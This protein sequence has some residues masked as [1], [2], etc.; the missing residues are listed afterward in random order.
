[1]NIAI[2]GILFFLLVLPGMLFR[3]FVIKSESFENP[4]DTSFKAEV[5]MILLYSILGHYIGLCVVAK[6]DCFYFH[7]A[8]FYLFFLGKSDML[9]LSVL[10]ESVFPFFHYLLG[11]ILLACMVGLAIRKVVISNNLDLRGLKFPISN[12]WDN[13]LSG[14][15]HLMDRKKEIRSK[16]NEAKAALKTI[17][18]ILNMD[19]EFKYFNKKPATDDQHSK[20]PGSKSKHRMLLAMFFSFPWPGSFC[21][22]S[23]KR[24]GYRLL[25]L[26][27][28]LKFV[29]PSP[30]FKLLPSNPYF[31]S[32][33]FSFP[34][35]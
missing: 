20:D 34:I 12:E 16:V 30:V 31:S 23:A 29:L 6:S 32:T 4:L 26:S 21:F 28:L 13:I 8:E 24:N 9:N 14:R 18:T 10:N 35:K 25:T 5:S 7:F 33:Y 17:R 11:Q 27:Y 19:V 15:L 2:G 22:I 3:S 1:M